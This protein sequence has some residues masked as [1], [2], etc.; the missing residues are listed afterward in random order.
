[1]A[2][3]IKLYTTIAELVFACIDNVNVGDYVTRQDLIKYVN[4]HHTDPKWR[5]NIMAKS[6]CT[7][8]NY[9]RAFQLNNILLDA[10][11]NAPGQYLKVNEIPEGIT[12]ADLKRRAYTDPLYPKKKSFG[13]FSLY[14]ELCK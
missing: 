3:D 14:E 11:D 12:T 7:I 1:M 13:I 2:R 6:Y 5:F 8:D 4:E 9:R 10:P